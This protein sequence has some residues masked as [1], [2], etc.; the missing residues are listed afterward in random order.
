ML[1]EGAPRP[2]A[3]S[4]DEPVMRGGC[5]LGWEGVIWG[6]SLLLLLPGFLRFIWELFH[7]TLLL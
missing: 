1:T 2:G 4:T 7:I 3:A 6:I 5:Y